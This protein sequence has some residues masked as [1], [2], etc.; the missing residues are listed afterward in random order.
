MLDPYFKRSFPLKHLKKTV[1]WHSILKKIL[2]NANTVLFTSEEEKLLARESFP[3]YRVRETVVPYGSFGPKCDLAAAADEF[4]SRWPELAG[5]RL[6]LSLGRIHPKKGTDM[7]IEAFAATLARDP[8]WHLVLAGP[9]QIGWQKELEA[10]AAKLGIANRITWPGMLRNTLKWGAFAASEV[11]VLPSHQENF[12]IA[13]AE[14]QSCGLPVILSS[15]INI[16]REVESY[17]AGLVNEDTV[18]GTTASLKRW[19]ELSPEE[20]S[21]VR[22]RSRKCFDEL[23][24]F[25][26]TSRKVLDTVEELAQ[27]RAGGLRHKSSASPGSNLT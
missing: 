15:R 11:F 6:A 18:E 25:N 21:A 17:W 2:C 27:S 26:V 10:L 9:D 20:I 7:L 4:I 3:G 14:A 16:W 8:Q 1:Y 5:K 13:V 19:S 24:N 12:G 23:F 22:E